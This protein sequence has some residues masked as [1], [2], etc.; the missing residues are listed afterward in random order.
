MTLLQIS[1]SI[2]LPTGE[3]CAGKAKV[4]GRRSISMI[5]HMVYRG[6]I[7]IAVKEFDIKCSLESISCEASF[8]S[9]LTCHRFF[10]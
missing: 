5:I 3:S 9:Q 6:I 2:L 1:K 7:N 8:L 4:V 10:E